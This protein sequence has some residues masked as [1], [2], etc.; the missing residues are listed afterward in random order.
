[1]MAEP[2]SSAA[3][4]SPVQGVVQ[5]EVLGHTLL[6]EAVLTNMQHKV[7]VP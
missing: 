5:V 6:R 2:I 3:V 1:M 7:L 4:G